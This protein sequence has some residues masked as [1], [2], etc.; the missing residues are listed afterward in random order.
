[1]D[2][3]STKWVKEGDGTVP[4]LD[5]FLSFAGNNFGKHFDWHLK[6]REAGVRM[7]TFLLT[8]EFAIVGF[9]YST[10]FRIEVAYF[11]LAILSFLSIVLTF[12]SIISC[13]QSYKA[14]LENAL[15]T[16]K[17][18]WL[19]GLTKT[20]TVKSKDLDW[21][22]CPVR[23]DETLYVP[24]YLKDAKNRLTT[25][26]FTAH[27]MKKWSNAY[28]ATKSSLFILGVLGLLAGIGAIVMINL[29]KAVGNPHHLPPN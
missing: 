17:I 4:D 16:T 5:S 11:G 13:H 3:V 24:R 14:S 21:S 10:G 7:L 9:Y 1:M 15:L 20:M 22:Q 2:K 6:H 18:L 25:D 12:L 8:A 19:K 28:F 23:D 29:S 26:D 27:N